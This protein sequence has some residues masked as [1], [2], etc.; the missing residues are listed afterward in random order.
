[1]VDEQGKFISA[2][3]DWAGTFVFEA[4][5]IHREEVAQHGAAFQDGASHPLI[6][7]LLAVQHSSR[8]LREEVMVHRDDQVPGQA[9][10]GQQEGEVYPEHIGTGRMGN[11]LENLVDW[12]LSRN[13]YWGT[14]L[15]IRR[16]E[17]CGK[18]ECVGSP[19]GTGRE[20]VEK[21]DAETFDPHSP[22]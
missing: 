20:G 12:A 11:W 8:V 5:S 14:P 15:N 2:V 10:R 19:Q 22:T 21:I 1:M 18:L 7:P 16:C 13:R 9:D 3:C 17:K 6:S 4:Q